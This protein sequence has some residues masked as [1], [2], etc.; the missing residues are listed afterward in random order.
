MLITNLTTPTR[1]I[2]DNWQISLAIQVVI[3]KNKLH[4][5]KKLFN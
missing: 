1:K 5:I 3:T 2:L 4:Q